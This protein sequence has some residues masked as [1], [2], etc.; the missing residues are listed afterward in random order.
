V[1][2]L[3]DIKTKKCIPKGRHILPIG[4]YS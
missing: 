3:D 1:L 4:M 2:K